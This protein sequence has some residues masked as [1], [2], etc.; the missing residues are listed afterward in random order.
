MF[1]S[2][3]ECLETLWPAPEDD[4]VKCMKSVLDS[5]SQ[6]TKEAIDIV[7]C[8]TEAIAEKTE[9][10]A[11][12]V[13]ECSQSACSND[14]VQADECRGQLTAAEAEDLYYCAAR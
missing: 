5:S 11:Q 6:D 3:E 9:C 8:Y 1:T 10:Y 7:N 2:N 4:V 12:N 14:V 13:A